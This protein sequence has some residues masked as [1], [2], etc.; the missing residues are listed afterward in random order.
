M[1]IEECALKKMIVLI[2]LCVILSGSGLPVQPRSGRQHRELQL[3]A[4]RGRLQ[5]ELMRE[6]CLI[7]S[8][9]FL[10]DNLNYLII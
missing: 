1:R 3:H 9:L 7:G 10:T 8:S 6:P 5:V 2:W 4:Q